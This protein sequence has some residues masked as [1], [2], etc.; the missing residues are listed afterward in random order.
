MKKYKRIDN[1]QKCYETETIPKVGYLKRYFAA[2]LSI[3]Y[4]KQRKI[5][6]RTKA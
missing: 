1:P 6:I 3:L 2:Y 5:I 4:L